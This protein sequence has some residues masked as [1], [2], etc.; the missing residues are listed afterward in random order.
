MAKIFDICSL[1]A[2]YLD[3]A[4][5]LICSKNFRNCKNHL[6]SLCITLVYKVLCCGGGYTYIWIRNLD[7]NKNK[8]EA[9]VETA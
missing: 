2:K 6:F 8:Q 9:K 7:Y 4:S 5:C 3:V 1:I